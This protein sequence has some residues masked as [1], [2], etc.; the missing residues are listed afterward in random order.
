MRKLRYLTAA[1][2]AV[3][4]LCGFTFPAYASGGEAWE[5]VETVTKEPVQT[6]E[7][8]PAPTV[9][10]TPEP[11]V[12]PSPEPT[13]AASAT[14]AT[15][16]NT[17]APTGSS[18]PVG[19]GGATER[20]DF[21]GSAAEGAQ[22][23]FVP[24]QEGL[25]PV[26]PLTPDGQGTLLDNATGEEGKEFFTITTADESVFYL[27][28]DRQKSGENV[29]FLNTVTVDDLMALAEP[30]K[31]EAPAPAVT[32]EPEPAPTPDVEPEPEPETLEQELLK[33][34]GVAFDQSDYKTFTGAEGVL[35]LQTVFSD[36]NPKKAGGNLSS[37]FLSGGKIYQYRCDATLPGGQNCRE[38]GTL[39]LAE[40][41]VYLQANDFNGADLEVVYRGGKRYSVK[42]ASN[43]GPY[44]ATESK[45]LHPVL[46]HAW[47][48]N[49][50]GKTLTKDVGLRGRAQR[51]VHVGGS[52]LL[53]A[54]GKLEAAAERKIPS[55]GYYF[56]D[57]EDGY[58][59]YE[60]ADEAVGDGEKAVAI[61]NGNILATDQ[62]FYQ[63]MYDDISE[64]DLSYEEKTTNA[65]GTPAAYL[66]K[67][68]GGNRY[69]LVKL[70]LLSR[71]YSDVLTI[72][73]DYII[74]ADYKLLPATEAIGEDYES[75]YIAYP[76]DV[77][78][79]LLA[80]D[81]Y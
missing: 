36:L 46:T 79:K 49:A 69:R 67:F 34:R 70:E 32:P 73:H 9:E 68:G 51:I 76:P 21:G 13:P 23:E 48:Y 17:G 18:D 12:T 45:Y 71:Y 3:V 64:N 55:D 26:N 75:G 22:A 39:P 61:L 59:V 11:A 78:E 56:D 74:T 53:I 4:L 27:V 19:K 41:P 37:V 72:A 8:T 58:I 1:L 24:T 80:L 28:I 2:C 57:G 66:P 6:A 20:A 50:D 31:E 47:R 77:M 33:K 25:T 65:D 15:G 54:D 43:N 30:G 5:D 81:G 35:S 40:Q 44:T 14:P 10:P 63:I 29:Y 38:V 42:S 7:P 60:V 16:G 52:Y 62:A